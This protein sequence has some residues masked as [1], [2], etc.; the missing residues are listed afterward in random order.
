[1]TVRTGV[2]V[3]A[4][5]FL[6]LYLTVAPADAQRA[7]AGFAP[8]ELARETVRRIAAGA[9]RVVWTCEPDSKGDLRCRPGAIGVGAGLRPDAPA[10]ARLAP[11]QRKVVVMP[12]AADADEAEL[13]GIGRALAEDPSSPTALALWR[14]VVAGEAC[15]GRNAARLIPRVLEGAVT[16]A[17][18]DPSSSNVDLQNALQKL[19]GTLQT[20]SNVAKTKHDTAK[21]AINNVRCS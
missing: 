9:V 3:L 16:T 2:A 8:D 4:G 1:M 13:L 10:G 15:A 19:Q 17:G 18:D 5:G 14:E 11:S 7:G 6:S 21:N 12:A 20:L